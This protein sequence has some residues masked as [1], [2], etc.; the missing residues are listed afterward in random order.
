MQVICIEW[1]SLNC[2]SIM[3]STIPLH[4]TI[5][6]N[7]TC[8][9]FTNNVFSVDLLPLRPSLARRKQPQQKRLHRQ[10]IYFLIPYGI[11]LLGTITIISPDKHF[12]LDQMGMCNQ[13]NNLSEGIGIWF[14]PKYISIFW[15]FK[16]TMHI[17]ISHNC[18]GRSYTGDGSTAPHFWPKVQKIGNVKLESTR[19]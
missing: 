5:L 17:N 8:V 6:P 16:H 15:T 19:Y 11:D 1:G 4:W 9:R 2:Y 7:N 18:Q 10:E 12:K 13:T 14:V 3:I